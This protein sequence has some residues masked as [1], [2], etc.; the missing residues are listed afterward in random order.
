MKGALNKIQTY[1]IRNRINKIYTT[2]SLCTPPSAVRLIHNLIS[3][4]IQ[5]PVVTP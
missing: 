1:I 3:T 4:Q 2:T 5:Y